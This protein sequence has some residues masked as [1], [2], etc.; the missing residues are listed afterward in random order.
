M[1]KVLP[2]VMVRGAAAQAAIRIEFSVWLEMLQASAKKT[3]ERKYLFV[4][5]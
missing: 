3:I 1:L 2:F 4:L 5:N